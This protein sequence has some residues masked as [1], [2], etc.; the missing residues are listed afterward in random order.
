M[1]YEIIEIYNKAHLQTWAYDSDHQIT[2]L[3]SHMFNDP[4][5][6]DMP[7]RFEFSFAMS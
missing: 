4:L 2:Y 6:S 1:T 5:T 7:K 3:D